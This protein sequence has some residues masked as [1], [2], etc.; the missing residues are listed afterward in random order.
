M[1]ALALADETLEQVYARLM[2]ARRGEA[3]E[4]T[5]AR[6]LSSW[7][8]GMGAMPEWLGLG[9][10]A[11]HAMLNHHFPALDTRSIQGANVSVDAERGAELQDLRKLLLDNRT[12]QT[13][14]TAWMAEIVTA[15]CMGNDHLW[16]DLGLWNRADLSKLMMDNFAPLAIRNDKDMKWK[17]FLYKQLCDAEG[18]YVCRSPSC[19]VCA[20]YQNCFGSED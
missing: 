5:L 10:K 9:E 1:D 2:S 12:V 4:E 18:I 6:I 7:T 17:K 3:V 19:E 11:F 13:D 20:D 16:Q 14:S 15:G 8:L